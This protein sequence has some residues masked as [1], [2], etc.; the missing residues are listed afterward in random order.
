MEVRAEPLCPSPRQ[1]LGACSRVIKSHLISSKPGFIE[2]SIWK[3]N[4]ILKEVK[5][6]IKCCSFNTKI[7]PPAAGLLWG[8]LRLSPRATP[9]RGGGRKGEKGRGREGERQVYGVLVLMSCQASPSEAHKVFWSLNHC[10]HSGGEKCSIE[11]I[12]GTKA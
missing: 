7:F 10:L 1:P 11:Q 5:F 12:Y 3:Q 6:Y 2:H 4:F 9:G 8:G